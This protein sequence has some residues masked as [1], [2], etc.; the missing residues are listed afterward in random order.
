MLKID[1]HQ[2]FWVYE[3]QRHG[4]IIDSMQVLRRDHLPADVEPY[5]QQYGISGCV[6]VQADQTPAENDFLINLAKENSFIKGVVG[7]VNFTADD[8]KDQLACHSTLP[9]IKGFRHILQSEPDE[10]YM[11]NEKFMKGIALLDKYGF[12]YDILVFP[13]HLKTARQFV[14]AHP[15]QRFVIDHI[16]K[17]DIK[18]K[19]I[20]G[21]KEDIQA[22]A[23]FKNVH[24]KVSGMV[25][26][27][28]WHNHRPVDFKPY[29]EV[30][31]NAFGA[32]R[33]MFGS[34]WPVCNVAGG[35]SAV[36]TVIN[37]YIN[38]LTAN[39]QELFWAKN[40]IDFYRLKI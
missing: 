25:T 17:P 28:D 14:S 33:V 35:Y 8:I 38:T 24:C 40:A 5:L 27:A 34:D 9:L 10:R 6:A 37:G 31:F 11:L 23:T 21:W 7:W 36:L 29:L 32:D 15:D 16:A 19:I 13:R 20:N 12:S 4:W 1:S 3:Q 18:A 2:H 30:I 22:L 39:E 26:E